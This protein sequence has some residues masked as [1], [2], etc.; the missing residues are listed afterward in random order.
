MTGDIDNLI[1]LTM[2][3]DSELSLFWEDLYDAVMLVGS[4]IRTTP[5]LKKAENDYPFG[6]AAN[7]FRNKMFHSRY[8]TVRNIIKTWFSGTVF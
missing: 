7:S 1:F 2:S 3:Q 4:W 8:V 5:V 6:R